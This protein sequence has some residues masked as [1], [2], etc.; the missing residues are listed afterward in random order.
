MSSWHFWTPA[1][2]D[3]LLVDDEAFS[4]PKRHFFWAILTSQKFNVNILE[5]IESA[6]K[7]V[8]S[9]DDT[10]IREELVKLDYYRGEINSNI[11]KLEQIKK[12]LNTK[13]DE[14]VALRDGVSR[15]SLFAS[16]SAQF[17]P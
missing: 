6:K 2:H 16:S 3:T 14:V 13:N 15:P 17:P 4:R 10:T 8:A 12:D 5:N 1:F 9:R 11:S 7:F